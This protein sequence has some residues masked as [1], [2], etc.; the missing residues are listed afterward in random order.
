[1]KNIE[2]ERKFIIKKPSDASLL[3]AEDFT[4]S[5]IVQ[6]YISD[7]RATHRVRKRTFSEGKIEYTE[8]TK[9]RIS[10]MSSVETENKIT[11]DRFL[12]LSQSIEKGTRALLKMRKTF[13]YNDKTFELD[14][15]PEWKDTCI[16]EVELEFEGE[17]IAFPNFI[18]IV[19]EVTGEKMYS[20][21]SMAHRMP[22][23]D[24]GA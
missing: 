22:V 20:N 3:A 14:F 15:Y 19:R 8:N 13:K 5:E 18:T 6:I 9:V 12:S 11:E 16:M 7:D 4:E 2:T 1:M 10:G 23:E 24:G 21:H 17:E